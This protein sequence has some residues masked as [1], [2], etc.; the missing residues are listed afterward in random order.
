LRRGRERRITE[1]T[2]E[3]EG[4]QREDLFFWDGKGDFE[5]ADFVG[6]G[7][8]VADA[9]EKLAAGKVEL[10]EEAEWASSPTARAVAV[11]ADNV[12]GKVWEWWRVG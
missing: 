3:K 10:L 4:A 2:E 11:E 6:G 5:G 12:G 1:N 9:E 8:E 7:V